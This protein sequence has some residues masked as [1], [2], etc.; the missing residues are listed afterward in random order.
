MFAS[1]IAYG[2]PMVWPA[3]VLVLVVAPV[4]LAFAGS[5][6]MRWVVVLG[7]LVALSVWI[8]FGWFGAAEE[9]GRGKLLFVAAWLAVL[10]FV[11]W[12][13]G[14]LLGSR[15]RRYRAARR[16]DRGAGPRGPDS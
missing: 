2:T 4:S 16:A 15:G 6:R 10:A 5:V 3:S 13:A 12:T 1:V 8:G 14:A 9:T 7:A 11:V